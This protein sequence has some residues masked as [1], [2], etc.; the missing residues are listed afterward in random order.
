MREHLLDHV[1]LPPDRVHILRSDARDW[2]REARRFEADLAAAGGLDVVIL[3]IGRNGHVAFNEPAPALEPRTHLVRLRPETRRA[4]AALAG[5]AWRRV[6]ARALS[7]G[8]ATILNG[9]AVV[10]LATGSTKARI[11]RRALTGP[12][13]TRVPASLLQTHPNLTVVLDR[14]AASAL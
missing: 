6:P 2:K 7:M 13:T 8:M 9:R 14:A 3:G 12:I 5:G 10:L 11:V 1:N 4:N